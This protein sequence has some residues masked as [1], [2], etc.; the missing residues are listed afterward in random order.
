MTRNKVTSDEFTRDM[1]YSEK[2]FYRT[3]PAA[4]GEYRYTKNRPIVTITHPDESHV[5]TLNVVPLPDR[6]LGHIRI[7]RVEVN[8]RFRDFSTD[9][10]DRFMACFDLRFQRGGG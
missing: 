9:E 5:L 2:D 1:G 7:E 4:I 6:V 8:F 10:R 3:L